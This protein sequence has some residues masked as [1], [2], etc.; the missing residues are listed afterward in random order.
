MR[1]ILYTAGSHGTFIRY[2]FDC[3]DKDTML[4]LVFNKN[5]NSHQHA[6]IKSNNINYDICNLGVEVGFKNQSQ[7]TDDC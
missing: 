1:N 6:D 7:E 4:P 2:L 5:G 3:Y